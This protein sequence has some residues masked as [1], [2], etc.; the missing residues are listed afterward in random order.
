MGS[1]A[2]GEGT[3]L[4]FDAAGVATIS[5]GDDPLLQDFV[6]DGVMERRLVARRGQR[7]RPEVCGARSRSA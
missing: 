6:E 1:P 5:A 7:R 3:H 2:Q 4:A